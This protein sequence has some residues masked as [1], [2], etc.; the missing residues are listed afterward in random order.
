MHIAQL[1][2][3]LLSSNGNGDSNGMAM[4]SIVRIIKL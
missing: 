4:I 2:Q 1:I 3:V